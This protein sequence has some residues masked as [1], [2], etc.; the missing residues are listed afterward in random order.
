LF[1]DYVINIAAEDEVSDND[2][3]YLIG[4]KIGK[5][6]KPGSWDFHYNY[7]QIESDA[8]FGTFSDFCESK[9]A[10]GCITTKCRWADN[11]GICKGKLLID[12]GN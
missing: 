2:T 4:L 5:T 11:W 1:A 7:R 9:N 6:K 3:A 8:L 12:I 10:Y